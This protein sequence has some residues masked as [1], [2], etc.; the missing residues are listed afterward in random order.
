MM[1][2]F[3]SSALT[4]TSLAAA[5]GCSNCFKHADG[6]AGTDTENFDA[7]EKAYKDCINN[8]PCNAQL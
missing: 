5:S 3:S 2:S 4:T 1:A 7:W 6:I 8:S